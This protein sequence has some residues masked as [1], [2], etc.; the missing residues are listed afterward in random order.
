MDIMLHTHMLMDT[1]LL[2]T[3]LFMVHTTQ[4]SMVLITQLSMVPTTQL[5]T[6]KLN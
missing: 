4:L 3:Q 6:I 5:S 2:T 1:Q